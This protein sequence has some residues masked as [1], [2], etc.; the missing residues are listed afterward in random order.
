MKRV[1][2][3]LILGIAV[4]CQSAHAEEHLKLNKTTILG[5]GE[6]PKIIFVVPWQDAPSS[7]PEWK[8]SPKARSRT[9]PLDRDVYQ[10]QIE[11]FKQI[12]QRKGEAAAR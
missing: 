11:Y 6:L 12:R 1:Y 3:I 8:P 10:R 5:N 4:Y 2:S 7:I 9:T